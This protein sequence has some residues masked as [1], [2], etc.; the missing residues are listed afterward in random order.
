MFGH[1]YPMFFYT[2][3]I[4]AQPFPLCRHSRWFQANRSILNILQEHLMSRVTTSRGWVHTADGHQ[5][6]DGRGRGRRAA[7]YAPERGTRS[8]RRL[9]RAA[10]RLRPSSIVGNLLR[11]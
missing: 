2:Y 10:P 4:S 6:A 8:T 7:K 1:F 5:T 9:R 11:G 3:L